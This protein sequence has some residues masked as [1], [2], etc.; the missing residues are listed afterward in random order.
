MVTTRTDPTQ[1]T[2]LAGMKDRLQSMRDELL[3]THEQ[4]SDELAMAPEDRGEDTTP[5][6]HP[7]DVADDLDRRELLVARHE[8]DS[9]ALA[10][11]DA[12]LARIDAGS[13][14]ICIDCGREIP[15]ERLDALPQATR[16]IGCEQRFRQ[17]R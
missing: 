3:A 9:R 17:S 16:D 12:A 8:I 5:S 7:A 15:R 2:W 14:W 6:Q 11:V 10:E 13:Y 1:A 4:A